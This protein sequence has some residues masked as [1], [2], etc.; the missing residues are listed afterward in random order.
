MIYIKEIDLFIPIYIIE[1]I[2]EIT[3]EMNN[4]LHIE[5]KIKSVHKDAIYTGISNYNKDCN[6]WEHLV[7]RK[8]ERDFMIEKNKLYAQIGCEVNYNLVYR[9][10]GNNINI[11]NFDEKIELD[12]KGFVKNIGSYICK[13][14]DL[15]TPCMCVE[16]GAFIH[17]IHDG[18][19]KVL[20]YTYDYVYEETYIHKIEK[21]TDN[22]K[23]FS[24]IEAAANILYKD[25]IYT[26]FW[27]NVVYM[28]NHIIERKLKYKFVTTESNYKSIHLMKACGSLI[29]LDIFRFVGDNI[30]KIISLSGKLELDSE[31][32]I[33]NPKLLQKVTDDNPFVDVSSNFTEICFKKS[34][35]HKV[36]LYV[37]S[38]IYESVNTNL[39]TLSPWNRDCKW[40]S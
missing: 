14:Y 40:V 25:A 6:K 18:V 8:I 17:F 28:N 29:N 16:N 35:T 33:I 24:R 4:Y 22:T 27:W 7:I 21:I 37:Y 3:D 10:I 15:S 31:G 20:F 32:Y 36:L 30:E 23:E 12:E 9:I 26:G 39:F 13:I 38:S 1:F 19:N 11:S 5:Q 34:G 2:F